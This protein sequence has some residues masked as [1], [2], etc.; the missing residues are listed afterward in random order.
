[1][2]QAAVPILIVG[3]RNADD[4]QDALRALSH[5][6]RE[7]AF[8]VHICENG[9]SRSFE[10]LVAALEASPAL[11]ASDPDALLPAD[12]RFRSIRAFRLAGVEALVLVGDAGE[13]LGYGG[14]VNRWLTTF[15]GRD[16]PGFFVLNPDAA[17]APDALG[18]LMAYAGRT[19]KGMVTGRITLADAPDRIQTRGLRFRR[20]LASTEAVDRLASSA[21]RPDAAD[22]EGRLD[23]PSGAA[24]YV[25]RAC[26]D[27]IG[28]MRED[29]F[30]YYEDMDWGMKAKAQCGLG[31]A[32]DAV[33][34]HKGG[35][36]IGSGT[37]T[38]GSAFSAYLDFRNCILFVAS[39]MPLWTPWALCVRLLRAAELVVV[40]RP[41]RAWAALRGIGAALLGRSGRP[42]AML[43]RHQARQ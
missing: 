33:I 12:H 22:V 1:M 10:S 36:T 21:L 5:A 38:E 40:G 23:A 25:T 11:V 18:Q 42:D 6:D 13:N 17:P 8:S 30:L 2:V 4:I 26:V 43:E 41:D 3:F 29:F 7:P 9:G 27:R 31:Y 15:D 19:G 14:G 34:V 39:A 32:Y 20:W 35:T 28:P 37:K 24:L 16:V